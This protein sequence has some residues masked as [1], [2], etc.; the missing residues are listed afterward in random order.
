MMDTITGPLSNQ[1]SLSEAERNATA[2]VEGARQA[3]ADLLGATP[4][5]IVFGR[6]MSQLTYDFART[7]AQ[8]WGP[9]DEI[10]ASRLD[11][12]ANVRAWVR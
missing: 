12:D 10:V 5:S 3:M 6:S 11:H 4:E 1:G 8:H 2:A 7:L 9:G